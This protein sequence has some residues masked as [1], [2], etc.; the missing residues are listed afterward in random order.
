MMSPQEWAGLPEDVPGELVGGALVEEDAVN[1]VHEDVGSWLHAAIR[2]W[3]VRRGGFILG[4]ETGLPGAA[5]G[6]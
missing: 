6:S 1:P 5:P 2:P 3:V 4:S